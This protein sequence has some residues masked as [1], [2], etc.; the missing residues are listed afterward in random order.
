V[1]RYR[2]V[3]TFKGLVRLTDKK[4]E[5]QSEM[6][7]DLLTPKELF[8]RLYVLRGLKLLPADIDG[9]ADP[10]LIIK[11][12]KKIINR[13]EVYHK[14]TLDPEFFE[15]FEIPCTIPGDARL[16][17][18]V[19]DYDGL[20]DDFMGRTIIDIEDRWFSKEW[21][22]LPLKPLERRTLH[23]PKSLFSQGKLELWVEI[24]N[25]FDAKQKP[26]IN[27]RPPP[28]DPFEL[29]VIVWG[30]REITIKDT[31][32]DQN[33]LYVTCHP[34]VKGV[35]RQTTDTHLRS[36]KGIGN[37]N[38]R[39]K[40]PLELP[41]KVWP[42]LRFQVWDMDFF[43]ANDSICEQV[44]TLKGLCKRAQKK[45]ARIKLYQ[46]DKDRFWLEGLRHPNF[47]GCQGK[48]EV[49]IELMPAPIAAQ[50]P[51]GLGRGDPNMNP[52]LPEPEGR[53][54]W[55]LLHPF[56]MLRELMGSNLYHKICGSFFCCCIIAVLILFAP[57]IQ[58]F[59]SW[60]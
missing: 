2:K 49:S 25:P 28:P 12:G 17:I 10:Y 1:D 58:V 39:M 31:I 15:S 51:A 54:H 47:A 53:V 27:I 36:K 56:D 29:R 20:G 6:T 57:L 48:L 11:L 41:M 32:T 14:H 35:P 33:D 52:F 37:F 3:G 44:I 59:N 4:D 13:R 22:K 24:L 42:R 5:K 18:E 40:F 50:L 45:K 38:W 19:W 46:K 8:V 26:M 23:S 30:T 7:K 43:S 16:E 34:G 60:F 21:R 55:S 9:F